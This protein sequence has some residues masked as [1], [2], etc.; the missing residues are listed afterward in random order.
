MD[1]DTTIISNA[2]QYFDKNNEKYKHLF[3]DVK[4]LIFE[5][6]D[7]DMT[8]PK[9]YLLDK[10]RK[11]LFESRYEIIGIYSNKYNIWNWAWSIPWLPK[12]STYISR[13]ILDYG[14]NLTYT[15][16]FL[17]AE[18]ITSRFSIT[19]PIQLEL[20]TAL[21]SYLSKNPVVYKVVLPDKDS[22]SEDA[23]VVMDD[24][25]I[26][27]EESSQIYYLFLLDYN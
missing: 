8:H 21:S 6:S 26:A 1:T 11:N 2:L 9:I 24:D 20:H 4:Y 19:D 3:T 13:K 25:D 23:A 16:I 27:K 7:K 12:S 14:F 17:K 10:N 18:L 15:K 22:F 5:A